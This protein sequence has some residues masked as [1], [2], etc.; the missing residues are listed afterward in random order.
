MTVRDF[1]SSKIS[2]PNLI[3]SVTKPTI[4]P[5]FTSKPNDNRPYLSVNLFGMNILPLVDSG[6]CST[7]L[8]SPN[9][10]L[11]ED[12]NVSLC[13][14]S[15]LEVSTADGSMQTCMG[16]FMQSFS[17]NGVTKTIKILVIP[18]VAH[19]LILAMDFLVSFGLTTDFSKLSY[20]PNPKPA[21]CT[22]NTICM[23]L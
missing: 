2:K 17:L 1:L 20:L 4:C 3:T 9:L 22:I 11:L 10:S 15:H 21:L 12:S 13:T 8:G 14:D 6:S 19:E 16:Y 7:I 18:S 5:V 23:S